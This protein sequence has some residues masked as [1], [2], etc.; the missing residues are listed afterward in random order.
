MEIYSHPEIQELI[1]IEANQKCFDCGQP[2]PQWASINNGVFLCLRCAGV[3]KHLC[4]DISLVRS[5]HLE[6]WNDK[7]MMFL[8]KGGNAQYKAALEE[9]NLHTT[10]SLEQKY[11]TKAADYYRKTLRQLVEKELNSLYEAKEIS[12]PSMEKGNEVLRQE[13][14]SNEDLLGNQKAKEEPEESFFGFVGGFIKNAGQKVYESSKDFAEDI[15]KKVEELDL[16][17]KIKETG[18]NAVDYAKKSGMNAF[19]YA[20]Q[21]GLN[22]V[23]YA[24]QSGINAVDFAKKSKEFVTEKT[25]QVYVRLC[26]YIFIYLCLLIEKRNCSRAETKD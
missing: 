5:I 25:Q 22:V 12:K 1:T 10:N 19:D 11:R 18:I 8:K 15:S 6:T 21:S 2:N 20:K 24:K 3:H 16:K 13:E 4:S 7:Y 23:D 14:E 17:N 9:Y 26:L